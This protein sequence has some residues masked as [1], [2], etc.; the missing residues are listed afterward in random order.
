MRTAESGTVSLSSLLD[1]SPQQLCCMET[2]APGA[3]GQGEGSSQGVQ[4][5]SS[6]V[7]GLI[8]VPKCLQATKDLKDVY[9]ENQYAWQ[10]LRES[11]AHLELPEH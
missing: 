4:G 8:Q 5:T 7:K 1:T 10:R 2:H 11:A 9:L 6:K 3:W